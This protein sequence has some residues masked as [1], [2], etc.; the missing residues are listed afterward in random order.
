MSS[1][2]SPPS[3]FPAQRENEQL[4]SHVPVPACQ[5]GAGTEAQSDQPSGEVSGREQTEAKN[6]QAPQAVAPAPGKTAL[7]RWRSGASQRVPIKVPSSS[8]PDPFLGPH[9]REHAPGRS[10]RPIGAALCVCQAP[11]TSLSFPETQQGPRRG[12]EPARCLAPGW[13][14]VG[15]MTSVF[16]RS[17]QVNIVITIYRGNCSQVG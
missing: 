12:G 4:K 10:Q 8:L 16:P 5:G 17:C 14:F 11:P 3:A 1:P 9:C 6:P 2:S 7:S 15:F 13:P